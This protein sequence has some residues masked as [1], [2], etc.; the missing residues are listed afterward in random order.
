MKALFVGFCVSLALCCS[1]L[2]CFAANSGCQRFPSGSTVSEP[3]DL[4]SHKGVLKV[5]LTYE[6][7]VDDNGNTLFCYVL[8]DGNQSP[9]LHVHPGD[10]L[11]LT[12]TNGTP[13][14]AA[15]SKLRMQMNTS[16]DT[17]CGAV[18]ADD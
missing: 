5:S 11:A 1:T 3:E 7:S 4:F 18:T 12:L 9:T 2:L 8:P 14:A 13:A 6:T 17:V 15:D 10:T 16:E